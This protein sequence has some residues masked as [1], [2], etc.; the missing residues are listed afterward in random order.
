MRSDLRS[1]FT[2]MCIVSLDA[3]PFDDATLQKRV[4]ID[5]DGVAVFHQIP[6]PTAH[7][8][9]VMF[10][11]L[12]ALTNDLDRFCLL[13][14]LSE[15]GRPSAEVRSVLK[16]RFGALRGKLQHVAVYIEEHVVLRTAAKFVLSTMLD[17]VSIHASRDEAVAAI[18]RCR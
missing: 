9:N 4:E 17:S 1:N 8:V 11:A 7:S 5:D 13:I 12:Q 16:Q 3:Q 10:D 2:R 15:A 14:D 6:L 18:A